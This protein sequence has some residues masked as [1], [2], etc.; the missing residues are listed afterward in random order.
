ML[1]GVGAGAGPY[2]GIR[3]F[4]ENVMKKLLLSVV[5]LLVA[6]PC[7][8]YGPAR[9]TTPYGRAVA[10]VR[11]SYWHALAVNDAMMRANKAEH[12]AKRAQIARRAEILR[13]LKAQKP[14]KAV[15]EADLKA[16]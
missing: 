6:L 13:A 2:R 1:S 5:I 15:R 4:E 10:T 9:C 3:C 11:E 7:L 14:S 16:K 8:A 12:A